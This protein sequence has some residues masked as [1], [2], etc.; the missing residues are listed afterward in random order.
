MWY[1]GPLIVLYY[2]GVFALILA[3]AFVEFI[4]FKALHVLFKM[5]RLKSDDEIFFKDDKRQIGNYITF[6]KLEKLDESKFR[7]AILE[8]AMQFQRLKSKVV[9]FLGLPFYQ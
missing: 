1:V 2:K 7:Q 5:E 4:F 8:K 6:H 9:F 3:W